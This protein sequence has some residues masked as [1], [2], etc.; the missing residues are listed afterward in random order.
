MIEVHTILKLCLGVN[1]REAAIYSAPQLQIKFDHPSHIVWK[2]F[3]TVAVKLP[4][5]TCEGCQIGA[6]PAP[7]SSVKFFEPD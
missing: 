4:L 1:D 2:H 5:R 6:G 7:Q 3:L